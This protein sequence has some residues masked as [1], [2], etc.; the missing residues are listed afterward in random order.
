MKQDP[1]Q[2]Y[3]SQQSTYPSYPPQQ[4]GFYGAFPSQSVTYS[5]TSSSLNDKPVPPYV[6]PN[7]APGDKQ[8]QIPFQSPP[9]IPHNLPPAGPQPNGEWGKFNGLESKQI[10]N[11]FIRKVYCILMLQLLVTFGIVAVFHFTP[12]IRNYVRSPRGQWAYWTS[13]GIFFVTY[14]T[15]ACCKRAGRRFPLNLILLCIL[16]FSMTY[17]MGMISAY[18]KIESIFIAVG[19]TSFVCLGVTLFSFQTRFDFTSMMGVIF[20]VS[21]ALVGFGFV[22]IFTYSRILYTVYAG[23]GA[24]AFAIFLAV[25]TQLIM[26]GKRHEISA[27]DHVFAS[28]MLYLDIVYIFLYILMLFGKRD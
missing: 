13:Y 24:V 26:G 19:L 20:A 4:P 27:E 21:L 6:A 9:I 8:N 7:I 12:T 22:C 23:L 2:Y 14:I 28:I 10:R 16:T 11:G 1:S 15:L 17:M 3:S 5:Q 25:D 18:F